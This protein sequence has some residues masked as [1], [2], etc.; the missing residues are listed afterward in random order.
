MYLSAFAIFAVILV[1]AT[2]VLLILFEDWRINIAALIVQYLGVFVLVSLEWPLSMAAVKLVA[3][4]IC[5]AVLGIAMTGLPQ[6]DKQTNP[7]DEIGKGQD[8]GPLRGTFPSRARPF[9]GRTF[10][11]LA[12]LLMGLAVISQAGQALTFI[13]VARIE[14]LWG[15]LILIGMG[16]L[17]L[18]F[19]LQPLSSTIALLTGLSGFEILYA[20]IESTPLVAGLLAGINLGLALA[21]AY[22]INAPRLE[23]SP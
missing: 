18:G 6:P 16:M 9:I 20:S 10:Y 19:T 11:L 15:G 2:S 7:E 22:L 13:P 17:K 1:T 12:T 8:T 14:Q 5:G 3:G 23:E 21:G 4:W